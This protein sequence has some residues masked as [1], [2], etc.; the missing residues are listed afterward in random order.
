LTG[1]ASTPQG[2]RGPIF[3]IGC[4]RSG[5]TW[6]GEIFAHSEGFWTTIEDADTF[7]LVDAAVLNW[8]RRTS[9]LQRLLP[10]YEQRCREATP[11]TFVDKSHQN[12][13]LVE[14][15]DRAFPSALYVAIERAPYPTIASMML[16]EGARRHFVHW[17]NY[18]IPNP[19]LGIRR[20]DAPDYENLPLS[21]KCALR[22]RSHHE[23]LA[24]LRE[25]L[26]DRLHVVRYEAL[27]EDTATELERL[28]RFAGG[29]LRL[30][31]PLR[32]PLEK[33]REQLSLRQIRAI[34]SVLWR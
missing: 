1:R 21:L 14:P 9:V 8:D 4:A 26:G 33:W 18:P 25:T 3:I 24:A 17:R 20:S 27:V 10:L 31:L 16:H 22:W 34:D 12:I 30:I 6:L 29:R 5:T 2:S 15:L 28:G 19:H 13:W 7:A 23:R 11:R 32:A